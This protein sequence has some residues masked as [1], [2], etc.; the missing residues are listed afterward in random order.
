MDKIVVGIVSHIFLT[1]VPELMPLTDV[2]ISFS[3]NILRTNG[4][5]YQILLLHLFTNVWQDPGWDCYLPLFVYML[6]SHD[7]WLMSVFRLCLRSLEQM[8]RI[9]PN[10]AYALILTRTRFGL[11]HVIF[12]ECV[13]EFL[14]L[15]NVRISFLLNVL[16]TNRQNSTIVW[17]CIDIDKIKFRIGMHDFQHSYGPWLMLIG[18]FWHTWSL[19]SMKSTEAGL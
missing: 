14:P 9:W 4:I 1:F 12:R 13:T 5:I 6:Q 15:N 3:L 8:D 18:F 16:I 11:L 7:P 10:F 19:Y 17:V 2:R